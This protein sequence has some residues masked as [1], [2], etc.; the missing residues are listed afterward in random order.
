MNSVYH[1]VWKWGV[2][3]SQPR[4]HLYPILYLSQYNYSEAFEMG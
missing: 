2:T 4:H 1:T 3:K